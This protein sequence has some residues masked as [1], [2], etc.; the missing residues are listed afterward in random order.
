MNILLIRPRP[1]KETIGLQHVMICEPLELEYIAS[2]IDAV[3]EAQ[4]AIIDMIVEKK[5]IEHFIELHQPDIA[6]MTGYIT[7][8]HIIKDYAKRIKAVKNDCI[9]AVGGVHA[10]VVPQDFE[11]PYIDHII[12]ADGLDTI[13]RIIIH[14]MKVREQKG[15]IHHELNPIHRSFSRYPQTGKYTVSLEKDMTDDDM[16]D[17]EG[18]YKKGRRSTKKTTFDYKPPARE[19]TA[20][21]RDHYYYMFHNPCALIKTSFGCPY[22]CSF[23]FCKEVTDGRYFARSVEDVIA[24]I[25]S[26]PEK[27]IYIVDDDF[28]FDAKRLVQFC[29]ALEAHNIEKRFLVYGR[30]DFV[31]EN[32]PLIERLARN[33]LSAVIVG[34]ESFKEDDLDSYNKKTDIYQNEN[35]V[36][37]LQKY[38][39]EVYATLILHLDFDSDDFASLRKWIYKMDLTFVNLQPL[40]PLPGTDIYGDYEKDLII[41]RKDFAKWDLAHLALMPRHMSIRRYYFEIIKL[42]YQIVLRPQSAVRL[43]SKYGLKD[44]LRLSVGSLKITTQ[45]IRKMLKNS[46]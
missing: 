23:C 40:T 6:A 26:I 1:D 33:G 28:L 11:S 13:N 7:H 27:E 41:K 37:I 19:K 17:I 21:Y 5:S 2:N 8:V 18:T 29:D 44:V 39:I 22:D 42:Y 3:F 16:T 35:A 25:M 43:I 14:T 15:D 12:E 30:A 45:Y 46:P 36:S 31:S 32:E 10:E 34:L 20:K 38:D 4:I 9:V 24:E